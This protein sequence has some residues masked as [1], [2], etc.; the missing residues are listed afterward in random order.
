MSLLQDDVGA[1]ICDFWIASQICQQASQPPTC[2]ASIQ[3]IASKLQCNAENVAVAVT[4]CTEY[5][6]GLKLHQPISKVHTFSSLIYKVHRV[7]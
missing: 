7:L 4:E 6:N 5:F 1:K 2:L 3:I